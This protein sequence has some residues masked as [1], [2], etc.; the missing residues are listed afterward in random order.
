VAEERRFVTAVFV[1]LV[2]STAR[3]EQLDPEDVSSRLLPYFGRLRNELERFGGTVEKF[4]GDAIVALFG[5]P[6]GN[7]DDPERALRAAF[8]VR[9]AI[10]ELNAADAWL[11]L[12]VRIGVA[13]GEALVRTDAP[14]TGQ[15]LAMGDMMNTAAR[16][17]SAAA[18]GTILVGRQT[19]RATRHAVEYSAVDP[20]SARG[21]AEPVEVWEAV[22]LKESAA[23]RHSDAPF[24]GRHRELALLDE[25][26]HRVRAEGR[27]ATALVLAEPGAGKTRLVA[28][29]GERTGAPVHWGRCLAYGETGA[30][31]PVAELLSSAGVAGAVADARPDPDSLRTINAALDAV[32]ASGRASTVGSITEGELH[33]GIRRAFEL[34]A[35][36]QPVVL[37]FDDLHWA[38]P[39]LLEL[40]GYLEQ[41]EAP[42]L[43]LGTARPDARELAPALAEQGAR[44]VVLSLPPLTPAES[45]DLVA[46]LLGASEPP[47]GVA[48]ILQAAAG[49]PL[50]LEETAH[51]LSDEPPR[52]GGE[53][54]DSVLVPPSLHSMIGARLDRLPEAERHLALRASVV[55]RTFW[56][57]A[58][59]DLNDAVEDVDAALERLSALDVA[60]ERHPSVLQGEREFE[61]KHELIREV[62][63]ARLPKGLRVD[64]HIRC[65]AWIS[66]RQEGDE[67]AE[68]AA[69]HLEHACRLARELE[70]SPVPPPVLEAADA[71]RVV[72][73]KAERREGLREADRLYERALGLLDEDWQET[74]VDLRLRRAR[75]TGALGHLDEAA[76]RFRL[77]AAD[78]ASLGRADVRGAA[79]VGLG[80]TRQKQGRGAEA[81]APLDEAKAIARQSD[82]KRLQVATLFELAELDRDFRG[83]PDLAAD[84]LTQALALA[85]ELGDRALLAEGELRLGFALFSLG[86]LER[87]EEALAR[88]A[89]I[90][91]E[92]GSRREESR[93]NFLRAIAAYAQGRP[94]EAERLALESQEWFERTGDSYFQ[95]Q[96]LRWLAAYARARGD[97]DEAEQRLESALAL[98]APSG[99]WLVSDLNAALAE[100]LVQVGRVDAAAAAA[101]A[102]VSGAPP[103]DP[104]ARAGALVASVC[105][106]AAAGDAER[107]RVCAAEALE[108]H[109]SL[110]HPLE[111]ARAR[112]MIGE[113]L[114]RVGEDDWA[115]SELRL[116]GQEC[117]RMGATT[118]L[119]EAEAALSG[120]E[121]R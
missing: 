100:L 76:E 56:P 37:A 114:A 68:L 84:E 30:Y 113:A 28:A 98:A 32:S 21:K 25:Q 6:I 71:L 12:E 60:E 58:V 81:G 103:G 17:Q 57:G 4:I 104:Q 48:S 62:A 1:D 72:A 18:P 73:E 49:N 13:T 75:I 20:V 26:W 91:S 120:L 92:L 11:A 108:L 34:H 10:A 15:G 55:G 77:V 14:S 119:G 44:R 96:N 89:A 43:I 2:G 121:S 33:W 70:R 90:G 23:R 22:R 79:L 109:E 36:E 88:S 97:V 115:A 106:A 9:A 93:A 40:I 74:A 117:S 105:V 82:D 24:V 107:V 66:D 3:A 110:R 7:E 27:P 94:D 38:D 86:E 61:F 64:L 41:A 83:R 78:A 85:E 111:L 52:N 19:Y 59:A 51:L 87:S 118:L 67:L 29:F 35:V 46:E 5:A 95:I 99:G 63:Y 45:E 102:A 80:N 16:I 69:H 8:G 101:D 31:A 47:P 39:A 50:Y 54:V 116:A 112:I 65:A 53:R 42:F